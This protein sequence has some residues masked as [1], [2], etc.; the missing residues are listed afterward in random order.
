MNVLVSFVPTGYA[1]AS[2]YSIRVS[3]H[4]KFASS[5]IHPIFSERMCL[6]FVQLVHYF[7]ADRSHP[8]RGQIAARPQ[9]YSVK[10]ISVLVEECYAPV[11]EVTLLGWR[12]GVGR[13]VP[14]SNAY[15]IHLWATRNTAAKSKQGQSPLRI[16]F[17][18]CLLLRL[19]R[20]LQNSDDRSEKGCSQ[21]LATFRVNS[22][23]Y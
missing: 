11:L 3:F 9:F 13:G 6:C 20:L 14:H 16:V 5:T 19:A 10:F 17:L 1:Q 23:V 15:R 12:G 18:F 7:H 2:R 22:C 4:Q 21:Q 8:L